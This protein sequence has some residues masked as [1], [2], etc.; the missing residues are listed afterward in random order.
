MHRPSPLTVREFRLAVLVLC[1]CAWFA[2]PTASPA[3]AND[4]TLDVGSMAKGD[5]LGNNDE[6]RYTVMVDSGEQ[7][8]VGA[9]NADPASS[10]RAPEVQVSCPRSDG[11]NKLKPDNGRNSEGAVYC[12]PL[13]ADGSK[14]AV[15][16]TVKGRDNPVNYALFV[17]QL[18]QASSMGFGDPRRSNVNL[19][20]RKFDVF[21]LQNSQ[22]SLSRLELDFRVTSGPTNRAFAILFREDGS[23]RCSIT[24]KE[25]SVYNRDYSDYTLV[26]MNAGDTKF[27]YRL[28]FDD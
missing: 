25:C 20:A 2:L 21:N 28:E 12:R 14:V 4:L 15:T 18:N 22:S 6:V 1:L 27:T 10:R 23:M 16:V 26:L 3:L 17:E 24:R 8:I 7:I 5:N 11:N 19:G 9:V 13:S